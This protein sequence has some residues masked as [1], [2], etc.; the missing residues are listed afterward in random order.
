MLWYPGWGDF[1]ERAHAMGQLTDAQWERYARQAPAGSRRLKA[2]PRVR[3]GEPIPIRIADGPARVGS[4]CKLMAV[5]RKTITLGGVVIERDRDAGGWT[6]NPRGEG[7][8]EGNEI[9]P[10]PEVLAQL[11]D[12]PHTLVIEYDLKICTSWETQ[13]DPIARTTMRLE[14][15]TEIVAADATTVT[16]R[17][18]P[19]PQAMRKE[20]QV[21]RRE[22]TTDERVEIDVTV[23]RTPDTGIGYRVFA[24]HPVTGKEQELGLLAWQNPRSTFRTFLNAPSEIGDV[25][26]DVVMRADPAAALRTTDVFEIYD[27]EL[28]F[29]NVPL[30]VRTQQR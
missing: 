28:V 14:S 12:G 24:R 7:G 6:M 20:F 23:P 18:G 19:L 5:A 2:R 8:T 15:Q 22:R 10:S 17:P 21:T 3:R 30:L 25:P 16:I 11:P 9:A 13:D 1:V 26:F 29:E 27:G 4:T